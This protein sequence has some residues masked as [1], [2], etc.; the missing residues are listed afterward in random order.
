MTE[1]TPAAT[2]LIVGRRRE[3][4]DELTRQLQVARV[5]LIGAT[6]LGDV[7]A[8][9]ARTSVDHVIMGAGIDLEDRLA[10]IRDIFRTSDTTTVH[11]KDRASG[12][13]G[14]LPFVAN[15]LGA[16]TDHQHS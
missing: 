12:P 15:I 14:F 6:S 8:T 11:L 7:R 13:D 5:R 2:V 3:V 9:F 16:L 4:I 10:I 1:A